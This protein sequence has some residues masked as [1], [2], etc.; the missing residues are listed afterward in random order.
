MH[1]GNAELWPLEGSVAI[2]MAPTQPGRSGLSSQP[3]QLA[4]QLS[5]S[6]LWDPSPGG[7]GGGQRDLTPKELRF[8][9]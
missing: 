5:P 3:Q 9:E 8:Q 6:Q 2:G 1:R 7:G 4:A